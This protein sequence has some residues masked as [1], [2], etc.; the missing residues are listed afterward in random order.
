MLN[1]SQPSTDIDISTN[2]ESRKTNQPKTVDKTIHYALYAIAGGVAIGVLAWG[3]YTFF[4]HSTVDDSFFV[5]ND[6]KTTISLTP[7]NSD[8]TTLHQT[9]VVY[10]YDG[11]NVIS[12]KTY[13][14]YPDEE[15]AK[16]AYESL[17]DQPEFVGAVVNGKYIIV[18]A[19]ESQFKGLTA[20]D[21]RQQAE[22]I[23][24]FQES[25]KKSEE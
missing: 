12:M 7:D 3:V 22:A 19:D 6:V 25:Q 1:T 15:S 23:K 10:E 13:F 2:S 20:S 9:H 14:E 18:T 4:G 17:K 21:V 11:E 8:T 5:S 16:T 24:A